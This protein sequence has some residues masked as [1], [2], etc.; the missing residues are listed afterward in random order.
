[1][2]FPIRRTP[3]ALLAAL[4]MATSA[5]NAQAF[6]TC[7]T[8]PGFL[9]AGNTALTTMTNAMLA[10]S[11]DIGEMAD[12]IL[13]TE[14]KI[15]EMADRIGVMADRIVTTE[16]LIADTLVQLQRSDAARHRGV[17]LLAP[18]TGDEIA[19]AAPPVI[20][21]SD[22]SARYVLNVSDRPD[23]TS[24]QAAPVLITP[25]TDR[26]LAWNTAVAP[27]TGS[28]VYLAVRSISDDL[29]QS[30]LSNWVRVTLR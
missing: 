29:S 13:V 27:F 17:L 1:M 24:A 9:G 20:T 4:L 18:A 15:G 10:L 28:T 8:D 19:R 25:T 5:G 11:G 2:P 22:A 12:R 23:A 30:E 7:T 14:D 6:L 3:R 16:Q 21:H 26:A